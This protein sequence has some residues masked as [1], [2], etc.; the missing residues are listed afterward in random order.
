MI[1]MD[2]DAAFVD[3][4]VFVRHFTG[5]PPDL[6]ERATR[7]LRGAGRGELR[8]ADAVLAEVVYVLRSF[9]KA[10]RSQV[11]SAARA[12][13]GFPAIRADDPAML[14]RAIAVY[15]DDR[16]DF[17]DAYLVAAAERSGV[18]KVVS[19]DKG[20]DRATAVERIV[21]S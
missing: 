14:L 2:G 7:F 8:L 16:L 3:T 18:C 12:I 10:D 19:L 17:I 13:V 5:D 1:R 6:A 9:Y 15:E 20:I 4:N 21:P 11:A